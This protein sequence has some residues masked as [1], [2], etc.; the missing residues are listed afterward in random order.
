MQNEQAAAPAENGENTFEPET[1]G[2]P[3]PTE[4]A[5]ELPQETGGTADQEP[6]QEPD[7]DH[8]RRDHENR[9]QKRIDKLT[10]EKY[11]LKGRLD[12]LEQMYAQ[13]NPTG[14]LP[15]NDGKPT[16]DTYPTDEAYVEALTDWK[17]EQRLPHKMQEIAGQQQ[18]AA[19]QQAFLQKEAAVKKD[20]AD[21]DSVIA[22]SADI[23]IPA[24]IVPCIITS[25]YGPGIRYYLA[26]NP[27]VAQAL[28]HVP[29][30]IAI[31]EIGRIE[32]ALAVQQHTRS[33]QQTKTPPPIA[34][35]RSGSAA[36][37]HDLDRLPMKDFIKR[38]EQ[39]RKDLHKH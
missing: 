8:N 32:A 27:E 14:V 34:P 3:V 7:G 24:E 30:Y 2:A 15:A 13:H 20:Y 16:R 39:M 26:K 11:E 22:E 5:A 21:Y 9:V 18:E 38:R 35:V 31:K 25:E 10:R 28:N 36:A 6:P 33:P 29:P 19:I 37:D 12:A 23:R 1:D 4:N 17:L